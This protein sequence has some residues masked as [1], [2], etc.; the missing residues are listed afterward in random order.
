MARFVSPNV[1]AVVVDRHGQPLPV[2][3]RASCGLVEPDLPAATS[4]NRNSP[5]SV[6]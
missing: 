1:Q 6:L 2:G 4:A 3:C 5:R